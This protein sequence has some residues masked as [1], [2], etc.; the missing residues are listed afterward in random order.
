[1]RQRTAL[2][3]TNYVIDL[4]KILKIFDRYTYWNLLDLTELK[5]FFGLPYLPES[6]KQNIYISKVIG[7]MNQQMT[8]STLA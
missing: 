3:S 1:M 6:I 4:P 2:Y 8:F 5:T 7:I